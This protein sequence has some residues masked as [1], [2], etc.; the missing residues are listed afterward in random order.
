VPAGVEF[1]PWFGS[2]IGD[3]RNHSQVGPQPALVQTSIKFLEL[4]MARASCVESTLY[5]G[6]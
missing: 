1:A 3:M 4:V 5:S 6:L 2:R